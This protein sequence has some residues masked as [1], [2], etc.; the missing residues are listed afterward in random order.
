MLRQRWV[1]GIVLVA[2]SLTGCKDDQ[3]PDKN[4]S[5][6]RAA[7]APATQ[8]QD[9]T[10]SA[11]E[12][13]TRP[14]G[15]QLTIGDQIYDFPTARLVVSKSGDHV[16]ARLYTNDP[17]AAL[18]DDYKFNSYD[19]LMK[20]EDIRDPMMINSAQWDFKA[21]THEYTDTPYGIF[22]D[23][24]KHQLQPADVTVK[25]LGT[26]A[27]VQVQI[28]GEFLDFDQS[29]HP[30]QPPRSVYVAGTLLAPVEFKE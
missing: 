20:L 19:L 10:A 7:V 22:L 4:A 25:F 21:R 16:Q 18:R 12:P 17:K 14:A 23:G 26:I 2:G 13:A 27:Q 11:A 30:G 8:P 3:K 24:V 15:T 28:Q 9:G 5:P 6:D 29:A 1:L